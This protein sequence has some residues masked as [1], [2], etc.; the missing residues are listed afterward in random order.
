MTDPRSMETQP[1]TVLL[2]VGERDQL[3]VV[4]ADADHFERFDLEWDEKLD[5]LV[6]AWKHAASP[7]AQRIRGNILPKP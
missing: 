3:G 2:Q 1:R 4:S 6:D 5:Q 7:N